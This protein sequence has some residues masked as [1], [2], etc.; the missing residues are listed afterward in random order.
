ME[1][2]IMKKILLTTAALLWGLM[3]TSAMAGGGNNHKSTQTA[4]QLKVASAESGVSQSQIDIVTQKEEARQRRDEMLLERAKT[5]KS[6][7]KEDARKSRSS[8]RKHR[9]HHSD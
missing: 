5:I 1:G 4:P 9:S 2:N 6:A 3:V 7:E 8:S